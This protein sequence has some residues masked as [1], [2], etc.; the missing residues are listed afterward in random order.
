MG[1]LATLAGADVLEARMMLPAHGRWCVE[2]TIA[3]LVEPSGRVTFACE[4]GLELS[5]TVVRTR[6]YNDAVGVWMVGGANG[7]DAHVA[8][9]NRFAFLRDPLDAVMRTCGESLAA[10]VDSAVTT[11][12]VDRWVNGGTGQ[13]CLE[14]VIVEATR[15]LGQPVTWRFNADGEIW[16]G[17]ETWPAV[18]LP[19]HAAVIEED[20]T[21][22]VRIVGCETPTIEPGTDVAGVGRVVYVEHTIT[23]DEVRSVCYVTSTVEDGFRQAVRRVVGLRT[24]DT[25]EVWRFGLFEAQVVTQSADL[26]TIDVRFDDQR[27]P[28]M[29]GIPVRFAPGLK[30]QFA[31]GTIVNVGWERGDPKRPYASPIT[32][33]TTPIKATLAGTT[34]VTID[35]GPLVDINGV[36]I[37]CG[38]VGSI[39]VLVVGSLDSWGIA[40]T[41]LPACTNALK[42]G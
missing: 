33:G 11:T 29:N 2:A 21:R 41:Q 20:A 37:T 24:T 31:P 17:A 35:G 6:A 18:T 38:P 9:A 4:N 28:G 26:S 15:K 13:S 39:P 7:L 8:S 30:A 3:T 27:L 36:S 19:D 1:A 5:G 12:F 23:A 14:A 22:G 40:V 10:D 42:A 34:Q 25:P 32:D 16:I